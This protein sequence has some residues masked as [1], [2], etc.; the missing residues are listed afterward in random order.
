[1]GRIFGS[2]E[3]LPESREKAEEKGQNTS[4]EIVR[5]EVK[6]GVLRNIE[7]HPEKVVIGKVV[8]SFQGQ[9]TIYN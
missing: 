8:E 2:Y 6:L 3:R 1:M 9:V 5:L 4:E 7:L